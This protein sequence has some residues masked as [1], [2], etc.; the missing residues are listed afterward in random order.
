LELPTERETSLGG[1]M[2]DFKKK[3]RLYL[4]HG[5]PSQQLP[6]PVLFPFYDFIELQLLKDSFIF[7]P[8]CRMHEQQDRVTSMTYCEYSP[9]VR[10][11][12][13][14][15]RYSASQLH[16]HCSWV[17]PYFSGFIFKVVTVLGVQTPKIK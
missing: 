17:S 3:F 8:L 12:D 16:Y 15:C 4:R 7:G 11:P 2:L 14:R 10:C 13:E 9:D 5:R 1:G 6:S